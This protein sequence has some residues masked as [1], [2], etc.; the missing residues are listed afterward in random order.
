MLL[1]NKHDLIDGK[2]VSTAYFHP[3]RSTQKL[4][5]LQPSHHYGPGAEQIAAGVNVLTTQG[6]ALRIQVLR[7]VPGAPLPPT[8]L[9]EELFP[10]PNVP[11]RNPPPARQPGAG[12]IAV[13]DQRV[14]DVAY[15]AGQF[16]VALHQGCYPP[17]DVDWDGNPVKRVCARYLQVDPLSATLVQD[18][19]LRERRQY[20]YFPAIAIDSQG[21]LLSSVNRSSEDEYVS[22]YL[23]GRRPTDAPG[24]LRP[25]RLLKAGSVGYEDPRGRWGDYSGAAAD[26]AATGAW[27]SNQYPYGPTEWRTWNGTVHAVEYPQ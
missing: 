27:F 12:T 4:W 25:P 13:N 24:T 21:N 19:R 2:A 23:T 18:V 22:V 17:N 9:W 26:P 1:L 10:D 20:F 8:M 15:R 11:F 6:T 16:W 7:G 3:A 5:L 14:L